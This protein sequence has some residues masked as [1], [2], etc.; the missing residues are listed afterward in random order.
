MMDLWLCIGNDIVV[1]SLLSMAKSVW[2]RDREFLEDFLIPN[3][4]GL[5]DNT[6]ILLRNQKNRLLK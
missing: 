4:V 2:K 1:V 5:F 3:F 6:V